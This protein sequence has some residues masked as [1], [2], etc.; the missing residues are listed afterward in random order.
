MNAEMNRATLQQDI[1]PEINQFE[2]N[3]TIYNQF[4]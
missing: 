3:E 1:E 4:F 2:T